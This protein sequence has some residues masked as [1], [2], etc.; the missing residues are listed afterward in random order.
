MRA[1][2]LAKTR[3]ALVA[4]IVVA[5]LVCAIPTWAAIT[6]VDVANMSDRALITVTGDSALKM[7]PLI[8]KRGNYVGF[9]FPC[10]L[11]TKGRITGI[12]SGNIYNVRISSFR[13]NPPTSRIVVNTRGHHDYATKWS[14]DRKRVEISVMKSGYQTVK[15]VVKVK[16][17]AQ[18]ITGP[19]KP[20]SAVWTDDTAVP[21]PLAALTPAKPAPTMVALLPAAEQTMPQP[22]SIISKP[23]P[24]VT[25]SL[26]AAA[27]PVEK[28]KPASR[29][30]VVRPRPLVRVASTDPKAV[31]SYTPATTDAK[32]WAA[33]RNICLNFLGADI[34]DVLKALAVQSGQNIVASKDVKGNVTVSLNRVSIDEAMDY[35]AKLSGYS[36]TNENGTYLVAPKDALGSMSGSA[37]SQ[38]ALQVASIAYASPDDVMQLVKSQYPGL[39]IAKVGTA[40]ADSPES[41]DKPDAEP[42]APGKLVLSGDTD[43]V[44]KAVELVAQIDNAM[45]SQGADDKTDIYRIKYVNAEELARSLMSLVPGVSVY[46]APSD[47]FD[48]SAPQGV[49]LSNTGSQVQK[50]AVVA[51]SGSGGSEQGAGYLGFDDMRQYRGIVIT[52]PEP[53]VQKA[54]DLAAL[55]DSKSPQVKIDAKITSLTKAGEEKLGLTWDWDTISFI[56]TGTETWKRAAFNFSATLE[57][58]ITDGN[59]ELL[60][61]PSIVCLEGKP[62]VFFVGDEVTYVSSVS[63]ST[64][65]EK[66]YNT[67]V[68]QAGVQLRVVGLVSKDG[69]ITLNLHPEVSTL[70]LMTEG[71][72][73]LPRINRRFT[74]HAVR[75]KNGQ[76]IVIG[77]LIRSDEVEDISKIPLLGD[78]PFFGNLFKHRL[79]TKDHTQVVMFIT[80]TVLED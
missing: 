56:E 74:D 14:A 43:A 47:G 71:D 55:L 70:K 28:P 21:K 50:A 23:V 34:N 60:A 80:A 72:V 18:V 54:M 44:A 65:G 75:V 73:T 12:G 32:K 5:C 30:S 19:G 35:V 10:R 26:V 57:A 31:A 15:P 1:E 41:K 62:G 78:I 24:V 48:L 53:D 69:Y 49:S 77:G 59:G 3:A 6:R 58:L 40:A 20:V 68:A 27:T 4:A 37:T 51:A 2:T 76:T 61:S 36:Y 17:E 64:S 33:N 42:K 25:S 7:T 13:P 66:T 79:K 16:G 29:A 63:A 45:R 39:Q 67:S 38:T 46:A 8:S 11:A 9:Q 52:G 22:A